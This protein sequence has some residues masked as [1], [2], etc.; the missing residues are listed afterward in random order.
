[1]KVK[2]VILASASPRRKELLA[3][4]GVGFEIMVSDK[5][6]EID[7][8]DPKEA[9]KK[10]AF[11]KAVDIVDKASIKYEDDTCI[12]IAADTIVEYEGKIIGK[13][14]SKEDAKQMIEAISGRKHRVYTAVCI[15]NSIVKSYESFVEETSVEVA[16]LSDEEI[17]DYLDKKE[18]Y[19]KAGA[20]AIQGY[21]S[22]YIVGIEGDYYNVMGLP[23]G[24]LYREY[25]RHYI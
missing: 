19:D 12:V 2:R 1:M 21:F 3:Q 16:E 11:Q 15:Y 10:Q 23:I 5:E 4:I 13:P 24:R 14:K 22:R 8:L 7:S 20:Y 6:T 9:C 25:L 18:P 17:E